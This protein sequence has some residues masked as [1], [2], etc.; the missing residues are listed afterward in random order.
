MGSLLQI[1]KNSASSLGKDWPQSW[2]AAPPDSTLTALNSKAKT[3]GTGLLQSTETVHQ[4]LILACQKAGRPIL[5][6]GK[7]PLRPNLS[8]LD[9]AIQS[10][11]IKKRSPIPALP[12]RSLEP[13]GYLIKDGRRSYTLELHTPQGK[14]SPQQ[15][16]DLAAIVAGIQIF[17]RAEPVR[18]FSWRENNNNGYYHGSNHKVT[19]NQ[20]PFSEPIDA[21]RENQLTISHETMHALYRD[22]QLEHCEIWSHIY[23]LSLYAGQCNLFRDSHYLEN[24]YLGH[25]WDNRGELFASA[26]SAYYFSADQLL[27]FLQHPDIPESM[28]RFGKLVWCYLRDK[29]FL[30]QVFTSDGVDLFADVS[31]QDFLPDLEEQAR[32]SLQIAMEDTRPPIAQAAQDYFTKEY[33]IKAYSRGK[34]D[35]TQ[36][37]ELLYTQGPIVRRATLTALGKRAQILRHFP[38]KFPLPSHQ[39]T[40]E[41]A[42]LQEL[43]RNNLKSDHIDLQTLTLAE[44]ENPIFEFSE[45][46]NFLTN[47]GQNRNYNTELQTIHTLEKLLLARWPVDSPQK[48]AETEQILFLLLKM[49]ESPF[50]SVVRSAGNLL[51]AGP[52]FWNPE[53]VIHRLI[54]FAQQ[55]ENI[56]A[57]KILLTLLRNTHRDDYWSQ[58]IPEIRKTLWDSLEDPNPDIQSHALV[59]LVQA[60]ENHQG[61]NL[62]RLLSVIDTILKNGDF[63][64]QRIAIFILCNPPWSQ[65]QE[66]TQDLIHK[67]LH[68]L[69]PQI[70]EYTRWS[71]TLRE[72]RGQVLSFE[73]IKNSILLLP[74]ALQKL[75]PLDPF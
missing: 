25:P 69:N 51:T 2:E 10:D 65:A 70:R 52:H 41:L 50:A 67:A 40:R 16:Q 55:H 9:V 23:A 15:I 11:R 19:L 45:T 42:L 21:F 66:E 48:Q 32:S 43:F 36:L 49:L 8:P 63:L 28:R 68:H 13:H 18:V 39:T 24:S 61:P 26:A 46:I 75:S 44:L 34:F 37:Q 71:L 6:Q 64:L 20:H 5:T 60:Q 57:R 27:L 35:R 7:P 38:E 56:E 33:F 1:I 58:Q 59:L 74:P 14:F 73:N 3:L 53:L 31:L 72:S 22:H 47:L 29:V 62:H 4:N 12:M 17:F 54:T 30:G